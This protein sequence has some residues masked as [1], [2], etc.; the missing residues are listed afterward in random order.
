MTRDNLK[1]RHIKK[2]ESCVFC[3]EKETIHHLFFD[4]VVAQS[5]CQDTSQYFDRQIGS[6]YEYVARFWVANKTHAVM[7]T[8]NAA[9]T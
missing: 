2:P 5:I 1:M 3:S 7:N 6:S 8:V 9:I 4:C